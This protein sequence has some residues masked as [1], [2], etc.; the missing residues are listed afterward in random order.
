MR[1]V[2]ALAGYEPV[3]NF[4]AA[5]AA[6]RS[7]GIVASTHG[8]P[9]WY[10]YKIADVKGGEVPPSSLT[11]FSRAKAQRKC[12]ELNAKAVINAMWRYPVNSTEILEKS[13]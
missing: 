3:K 11:F 1:F 6:V 2:E 9:R 13:P 4:D 5:V 10:V 7:H 8:I 12:D